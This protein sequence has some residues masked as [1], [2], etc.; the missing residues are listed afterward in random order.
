VLAY[1]IVPAH[2]KRLKNCKEQKRGQVEKRNHYPAALGREGSGL[3][4]ELEENY[5]RSH[6]SGFVG[7]ESYGGSAAAQRNAKEKVGIFVDGAAQ[8][9]S[10]YSYVREFSSPRR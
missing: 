1:L 10:Y 5:C 2:G 8:M 4:E 9:S 7:P 3:Q 6:H